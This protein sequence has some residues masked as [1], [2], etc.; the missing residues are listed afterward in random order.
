VTHHLLHSRFYHKQGQSGLGLEA[1]RQANAR[2]AELNGYTITAEFLEVE[3]AK[4]ADALERRPQLAA[5]LKAAKKAGCAVLVAKLDRLSLSRDVRFIS[6]LMAHR[7]SFIVAELGPS[8]DAFML[9][10]Y[11]AVA[12]QERR[13]IAERTKAALQAAKARGH[14]LGNA[15]LAIANRD[16]AADRAEALRDVFA[17][18][19]DLSSHK[20]AAELN[21]RGVET[22]TGA[23]WS[24]KTVLRVR[25]RLSP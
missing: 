7:V 9:H 15:A 25:S 1:Q 16:A 8:V 17:E 2:F 11:A 13:K 20:A 18:L 19:A 22:P 6:G 5:A 3:T 12:E 14:V 21:A 23:P 24:A 4:G 10:V